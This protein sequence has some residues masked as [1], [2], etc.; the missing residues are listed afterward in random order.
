MFKIELRATEP[1]VVGKRQLQ[2]GWTTHGLVPTR[3]QAEVDVAW[4][5][6]ET[7]DYLNDLGRSVRVEYRISSDRGELISSS[8]I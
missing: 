6:N 1:L 2:T 4:I 7:K 5:I 8:T 3:K